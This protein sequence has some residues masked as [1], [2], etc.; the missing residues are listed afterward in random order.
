MHQAA[1]RATCARVPICQ[2]LYLRSL[3]PR[4]SAW[5]FFVFWG[6]F[7]LSSCTKLCNAFALLT[8]AYDMHK[9]ALLAPT[10]PYRSLVYQ[11]QNPHEP[12]AL[13][14]RGWIC[15]KRQMRPVA[16]PTLNSMCTD[17]VHDSSMA[18]IRANSGPNVPYRWR[19]ATAFI[20]PSC[21]A[22]SKKNRL[23]TAI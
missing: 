17:A 6:F 19:H 10:L 2:K 21:R 7:S 8:A 15:Q 20:V 16:T 5:P 4:G 13:Q 11:T 18:V 3:R 1:P 23:T 14:V 9:H 22:G 12:L